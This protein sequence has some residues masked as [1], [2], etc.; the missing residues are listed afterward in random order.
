[1]NLN[2]D[3]CQFQQ[4]ITLTSDVVPYL[5]PKE[6]V[7]RLGQKQYYSDC[8]NVAYPRDRVTPPY[9]YFD[10]D[11]IAED[12]REKIYLREKFGPTGGIYLSWNHII[13]I[14]LVLLLAYFLYKRDNTDVFS[15]KW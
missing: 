3:S 6:Q 11:A 12:L 4:D 15:L 5:S 8:S 13:I 2:S 7:M 10:K 9:I 1:M 14:L